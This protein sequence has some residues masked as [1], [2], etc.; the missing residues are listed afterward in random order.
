[1]YFSAMYR[2][3]NLYIAEKYMNAR[4]DIAGRSSAR[5]C[6]TRVAR[7]VKQGWLGGVKQGWLGG[8]KQGW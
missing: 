5:G 3:Y 7:G 6:Q 2:L 1:M 8:V 4:V